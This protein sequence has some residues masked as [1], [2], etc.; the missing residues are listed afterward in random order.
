[1]YRFGEYIDLYKQV[2]DF[3]NLYAA[4]LEVARG[5][6]LQHEFQEFAYHLEENLIGIQNDLIWKTYVPLPTISFYVYEP[7]ERYI[8][9]P[10]IRDRI[11]HHALVRIV[12]Q[13][14][15]RTFDHTSFACQE[16]K[17]QIAV[18]EYLS[19]LQRKA[20]GTYGTLHFGVTAIDIHHFFASIDH[21]KIKN[22]LSYVFSDDPDVIWL[23]FQIIDAVGEGLPIGFLPSQYEANLMGTAIDFF[24]DSI[25]A[26]LRCRYMDDLRIYSRDEETARTYLEQVDEFCLTRLNL[27]LNEKKSKATI[28]SGKDTFCGYVVCPHHLEP[29][30]STV[31]RGRRRI[32]KKIKD[33]QNG[34]ISENE[35][36]ESARNLN[37]Y[38]S[39][40]NGSPTDP[41][42]DRAM[43]LIQKDES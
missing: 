8:T 14:F 12:K 39:H 41:V 7:K 35:L 36:E 1:M 34:I 29:K 20:I 38:L 15:Y 30:L 11:V 33:Y 18:C 16:G 17:G 24:L 6:R 23:S 28:F 9:R 31:K 13:F 4:Y 21:A 32:L 25:G 26:K 42:A 37:L 2:Y 3:D 19:K 10:E 27:H 22:L 40:T 43:M 5:K